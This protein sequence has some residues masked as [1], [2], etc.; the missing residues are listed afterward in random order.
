MTGDCSRHLAHICGQTVKVAAVVKINYFALPVVFVGVELSFSILCQL[1][2]SLLV[3]NFGAEVV[4]G[5][6]YS[7]LRLI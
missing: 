1:R 6:I 7:A 5:L 2:Q 3:E 4:S